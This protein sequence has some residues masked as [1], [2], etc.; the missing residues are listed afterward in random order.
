VKV[1]GSPE[2][3]LE[4][5]KQLTWSRVGRGAGSSA[6]NKEE[7]PRLQRKTQNLQEDHFTQ[8]LPTLLFFKK[9]LQQHF[10][11]ALHRGNPSA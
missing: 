2:T 1:I 10:Q 8:G 11:F 4:Q 6:V 5:L 3:A 7:G 9:G